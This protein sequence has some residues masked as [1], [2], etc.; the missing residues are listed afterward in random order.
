MQGEVR[1]LAI[2]ATTTP[3][4]RIALDAKSAEID[5]EVIRLGESRT[6][7]AGALSLLERAAT[8][9]EVNT[10]IRGAIDEMQATGDE[11]DEIKRANALMIAI[12]PL[13]K[14]E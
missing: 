7:I 2:L 13:L 3:A 12:V 4:R 10:A 5:T 14:P 11:R 6:A 8:P 1:R 9:A